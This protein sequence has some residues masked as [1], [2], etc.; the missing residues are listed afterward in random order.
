[1]GIVFGPPRL[2]GSS[3]GPGGAG[4]LDDLRAIPWVFAWTQ[5][6]L[7]LPVWLGGGAALAADA[8]SGE[9]S[10]G[11]LVERMDEEGVQIDLRLLNTALD[12]Y[13]RQ[14]QWSRALALLPLVAL[15]R[16]RK[17]PS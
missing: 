14:L 9:L 8:S 6:R 3:D 10:V 5:T 17:H 1:M 12:G 4:G 13:A 11:E 16:A 7:H 15:V 2:G